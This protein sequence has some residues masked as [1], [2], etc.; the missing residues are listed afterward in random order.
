M[1]Y[2]LDVNRGL[3]FP[4]DAYCDNSGEPLLADSR[5]RNRVASPVL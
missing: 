4:N 1:K 3:S 5:P 2:L